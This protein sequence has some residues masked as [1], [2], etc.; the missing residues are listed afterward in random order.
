MSW[1]FGVGAYL[2]LQTVAL[3]VAGASG[4][5]L[6]TF[7]TSS[8]RLLGRD[9]RWDYRRRSRGSCKKAAAGA[10]GSPATSGSIT[11]TT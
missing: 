7:N 2:L 1:L 4:I 3:M 8:G 10:N 5:W 6:S 9:E 11:S